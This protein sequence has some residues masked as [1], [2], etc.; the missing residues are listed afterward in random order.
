[1][2]TVIQYVNFGCIL[3][4][5][6]FLVW[7]VNRTCRKILLLIFNVKGA[8]WNIEK[9]LLDI[10]DGTKRFY[11]E[12]RKF[13]RARVKSGITVEIAGSNVNKYNKA[14]DISR[15]GALLRTRARFKLGERINMSIYLPLFP[16]PVNIEARITRVAAALGTHS[17]F[18]LFNVG[19]EFLN[20]IR[21]DNEKLVETVDTLLKSEGTRRCGR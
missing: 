16:Q 20:I 7:I 13:P 21:M 10:R 8:R 3:L 11:K 12:K 14:L 9:L 18:P 6:V 17:L 15:G 1:M 4:A 5:T 2:F 19:V